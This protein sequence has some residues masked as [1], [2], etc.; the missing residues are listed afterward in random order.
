MLMFAYRMETRR[1]QI[2]S[3]APEVTNSIS[4]RTLATDAGGFR[5]LFAVECST[6]IE[7]RMRE[8]YEMAAR[9]TDLEDTVSWH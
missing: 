1:Y 9:I 5:A 4:N 7:K 8:F 2:R 6:I 3:V